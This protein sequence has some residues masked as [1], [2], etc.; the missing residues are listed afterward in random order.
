MLRKLSST[1]PTYLLVNIHWPL[2]RWKYL[3][4]AFRKAKLGCPCLSSRTMPL[5]TICSS[6]RP[7]SGDYVESSP[8]HV[9]Q[10]VYSRSI[11]P[12]N[13]R[14]REWFFI[15][16]I[17][18]PICSHCGMPQVPTNDKSLILTAAKKI[19][20]LSMRRTRLVFHI[21]PPRPST[22]LSVFTSHNHSS[23]P[24]SI[25]AAAVVA[26]LT[27]TFTLTIIATRRPF[28]RHRQHDITPPRTSR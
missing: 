9:G 26:N 6:T 25:A 10:R 28:H 24:H 27:F 20:R 2:H 19:L 15:S 5:A 18:A 23:V 13:H 14:S 12:S 22:L 11:G 17:H 4:S 7:V 3:T 21:R 1:P 16:R 8:C